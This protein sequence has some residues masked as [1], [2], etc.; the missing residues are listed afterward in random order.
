MTTRKERYVLVN[1]A[2]AKDDPFG[3]TASS[4]RRVNVIPD[5]RI[6]SLMPCLV[7]WTGN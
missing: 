7:G 6:C 4:W 2:R 5:A 1:L 3:S